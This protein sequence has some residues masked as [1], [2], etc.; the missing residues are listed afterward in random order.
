MAEKIKLTDAIVANAQLPEGSREAV[1]WDSDVTGFGLRVRSGSKTWIVFYR[2]AGMGRATTAKRFKLGTPETIGTATEARRLARDV[3]GRVARGEDPATERA[4]RKRAAKARVRDLLN[5]YEA[6]QNARGRMNVGT[7]LSVIRRGLQP[8]LDRDVRDL[9]A[10]E[11]IEVIDKIAAKGQPGA[12]AD[13]RSRCRAFLSWC[14]DSRKV[15]DAN[16]LLEHRRE[17]PTRVQKLEREEP[18]R[19]LGADE[20]K[21]VWQASAVPTNYNRIVRFVLLTGCRRTEA[22]LVSRGMIEHEADGVRLLVIPKAVTKSGRDHRLPITPQ[23]AVLMEGC[24]EDARSDLFFPSQKTG[25]AV[26][27]WSKLHAAFVKTCGVSFGLHDL[28]RTLKTGLD[29]LGVDSDI[30]EICLNHTRKGLEGIYNKNIATDEVRA[31]F[32]LWANVVSP[33]APGVA[34]ADK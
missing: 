16:P 28:R 34:E 2:P 6:H 25:R 19:A 8:F 30:S 5:E 27:G 17:R 24:P 9:R 15:I 21:A 22:S 12:A 11:L 13:F 23:L 14:R 1:L 29:A 18:G 26:K 10:A 31:A 7:V 3:L 4:E 20:V 33:P 32:T